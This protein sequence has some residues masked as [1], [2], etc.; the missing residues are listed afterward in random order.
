VGFMSSSAI[1]AQII[2]TEA[3]IYETEEEIDR[4]KKLHVNQEIGYDE[5]LKMRK[6]YEDDMDLQYEVY[7]RVCRK[8]EEC[9]SVRHY[10]DYFCDHF[11]LKNKHINM[12]YTLDGVQSDMKKELNRTLEELA[13]NEHRLSRRIYSLIRCVCSQ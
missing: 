13:Y 5:F 9:T 6:D 8:G 3:Q 7:Q 12:L 4:L 1:M 11:H 10:H 2:Q